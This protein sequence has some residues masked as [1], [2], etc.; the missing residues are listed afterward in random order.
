MPANAQLGPLTAERTVDV[1]DD[2]RDVDED[3]IDADQVHRD[4]R[5]AT[6]TRA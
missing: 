6:T 1:T 4:E 2:E 5:V 3:H